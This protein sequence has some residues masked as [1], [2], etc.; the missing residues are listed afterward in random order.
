SIRWR[1]A[2]EPKMIDSN[3]Q[4]IVQEHSLPLSESERVE[5]CCIIAREKLEVGDFEAG[6]TAVQPWWA[7]GEWPRHVGLTTWAAAELFFAA[8]TLSSAIASTKKLEGGQ[9]PSE[10]L[11]SGAITLFEQLG[12]NK[13]AS[14]ARVELAF[15]Y[16]LQGLF[17]LARTSLK[18]SL[19]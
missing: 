3:D 15:C 1:S 14:E 2:F 13:R 17:D 11:L 7:M 18:A 19:E 8:G 9:K 5:A 16:F 10:A 4:T 12:Q 6:L